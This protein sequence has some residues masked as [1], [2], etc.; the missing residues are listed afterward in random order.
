M[1]KLFFYVVYIGVLLNLPAQT[2]LAQINL[3]NKGHSPYRILLAKEA[4]PIEKES[5]RILQDYF[6]RVSGQRLPIVD[7][8]S[9]PRSR[10]KLISIGQTSLASPNRN[11][12]AGDSFSIEIDHQSL[13]FQGS[14]RGLLYGIY[15]F[16]EQ[17]LGCRKWAANEPANCPKRT[18]IIIPPG[19]RVQEEPA[20]RY[21]EVYF[22][23]EEDIEYIHWHRLDRLEDL[24][25][26]WGHSFSSWISP[27]DYFDE[28]PDYFAYYNG[29]RN[30]DQL[31]LSNAHVLDIITGA[32]DKAIQAK[33]EA[34][35]W[36]ISPNDNPIYC[37]C[38]DCRRINDQEGGPQ[39]A[40]IQFVNRLAERFPNTNF[41]TLAYTYTSNAP[42]HLKPAP[43][44]TVFLS[45]IDVTRTHPI[46]TEP[47]AALFRKQLAEWLAKTKKVFIWDY[48]TQFTNYLAP[49]PNVYTM[50]PNIRYFA[51]MGASGI[52]AQGSEGSYSDM[53][54]LKAYLLSKLLWDPY[55]DPHQIIGEFVNG[56][57]KNAAPYIMKYLQVITEAAQSDTLN[58]YGNPVLH[59]GGFLS[60]QKMD[61]YSTILDKA[62]IVAEGDPV[63]QS[64][65]ERLR[66][67]LDYTYLQQAR[68]YGTEPHGIFERS[69]DA[70]WQIRKGFVK[71]VER[72]VASAEQQG[73][74]QLSEGGLQAV[75]YQEE[76]NTIFHKGVRENLASS[77]RIIQTGPPFVQDFPAKG[78][79][80]LIDRMPGYHDFSYNWLCFYGTSMAFTLDLQKSQAVQQIE[81]TFLTDPRHW[82]FAPQKVTIA[83]STD[84]KNFTPI[85]DKE[86]RPPIENYS[87]D[88]AV[89]SFEGTKEPIRYIRIVALPFDRLP[90]W[91]YHPTKKSMIACD[92]VWIR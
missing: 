71:R 65:I 38:T 6:Q 92:E 34:R 24:W 32:L 47:S 72:F 87:I 86:S 55:I 59:H 62:A 78:W 82:I 46:P 79:R 66:L 1:N 7:K 11:S 54:E 58:I 61:S 69:E 50:Q 89:F 21:R 48:Y 44:V 15:H 84:G 39:G 36:S 23:I 57:Y 75:Q 30:P 25:G 4:S 67:P 14:G 49:F 40:L 27:S 29:S 10:Q 85:G 16:I 56:Y 90:S 43:N 88:R 60:P 68:F 31:C 64:R 51:D 42:L 63:L 13:F 26:K 81:L 8:Y 52:F 12:L 77:A 53:A 33:P 45:S 70:T 74:N 17:T 83:G 28:H 18:E 22:P 91:R 73:A 9:G 19:Y 80:T 35:F 20:F 37:Q 3:L 41:T 5:A 76:W 2:G